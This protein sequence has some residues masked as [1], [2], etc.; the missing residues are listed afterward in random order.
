[1][2]VTHSRMIALVCVLLENGRGTS[3]DEVAG[4]V[5]IPEALGL[6]VVWTA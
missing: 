4:C 1:M 3:V 6:F 5:L 2:G